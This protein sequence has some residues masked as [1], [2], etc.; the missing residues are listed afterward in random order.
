[1]TIDINQ[2]RPFREG[3]HR[4]FISSENG[5]THVGKNVK[6]QV[7]RQFKIDGEVIPS[8]SS[9]QR[10]DYLLL[11]DETKSS[12]YIELKGSDIPKAIEQIENTVAM[13]SAK[14]PQYKVFRRI[15]Y[16]TGS[17]K[18]KDSAV[19]HWQ[20]KHGKTAIIKERKY[21]DNICK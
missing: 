7:V 9:A 2:Y 19:L 14:I 20:R 6:Q 1:M 21:E 8:G 4:E 13:I 5:C 12:Y 17:H 3:K 10:C 16:K 11:N 18:V 15:I